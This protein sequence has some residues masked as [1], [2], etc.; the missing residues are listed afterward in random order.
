MRPYPA[1]ALLPCPVLPPPPESIQEATFSGMPFSRP[2]SGMG[3]ETP[4]LHTM[5]GHVLPRACR[6][7]FQLLLL[8]HSPPAPDSMSPDLPSAHCSGAAA[9]TLVAALRTPG[10]TR[11]T[12]HRSHTYTWPLVPFPLKRWER[13][14]CAVLSLPHLQPAAA[15]GSFLGALYRA[16]VS[17]L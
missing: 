15:A 4:H 5:Q 10:L 12:E 13:W 9:K 8:C 1:S 6:S 16:G 17:L 7:P 2:S 3:P 14:P 11:S